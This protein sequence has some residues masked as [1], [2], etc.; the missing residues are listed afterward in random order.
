MTNGI[1][2][3][4]CCT[5]EAASAVKNLNLRTYS[6]ALSNVFKFVFLII[7]FSGSR[8]AETVANYMTYLP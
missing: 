5:R 1:G 4:F 6:C 3:E 8:E 7:F 2:S